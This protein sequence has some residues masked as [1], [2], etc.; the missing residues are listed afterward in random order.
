[1]S[2]RLTLRDNRRLGME[3]KLQK[4]HKGR[5]SRPSLEAETAKLIRTDILNGVWKSG[6]RLVEMD[7]ADSFGVSQS[8]VRGALKYLQADALVVHKPRRGHFVIEITDQDIEE[9]SLLR[10]TLESLG[11]R[12]AAQ[13]ITDEGRKRLGRL[14]E[15]MRSASAAGNRQELIELDLAFHRAVVEIAGSNRLRELYKRLVGPALLFLRMAD[16]LY[17]EPQM[18]VDL[19][20]P[21]LDAISNGD[22]E[23]AFELAHRHTEPDAQRIVRR[24]S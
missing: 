1:M 21:L 4:H 20:E 22:A 6:D 9:I 10:D 13:T 3:A 18:I 19:H 12:L 24:P 5:L 15:E 14:L 11:A 23:R 8:T 16:H 2:L 17:P 7:L